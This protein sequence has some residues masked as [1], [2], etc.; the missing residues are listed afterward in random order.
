MAVGPTEVLGNQ[1]Y[2]RIDSRNLAVAERSVQ[3]MNSF[4]KGSVSVT[5]NPN[6]AMIP[7]HVAN[8]IDK[9]VGVLIDLSG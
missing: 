1:S 7:N 4:M 6:G 9:G 8:I 5:V 3:V 2:L